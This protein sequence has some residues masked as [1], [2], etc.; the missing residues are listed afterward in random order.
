MVILITG[1]SSGFGR[2]M[3]QQ[4][5]ADGHTVYG[6]VRREVEQLPG[7]HYLRADVRDTAAVQAAV[8]AVLEAEGWKPYFFSS[9]LEI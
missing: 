9:F 8:E 1:I 6:T 3:A 2:A 5:S 7:V 4:L